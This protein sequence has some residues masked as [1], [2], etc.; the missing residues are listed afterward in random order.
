MHRR[1]MSKLSAAFAVSVLALET[2]CSKP[3]EAAYKDLD[4]REEVFYLKGQPFTGIARESYK[5]GKPAKEYPMKK[6]LIHGV[7]HEWYEN[8]QMSAET[9][10]D[11]GHRHGLNRYWSKEGKLTK[12]QVYDHGTSVSVKMYP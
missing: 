4:W 8:G 1:T 6:G 7:M 12:E 2:A 11:N 9:H 5:D 3:Q 10:F